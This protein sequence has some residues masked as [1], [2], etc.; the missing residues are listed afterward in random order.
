MNGSAAYGIAPQVLASVA[1]ITTHPR[2]Y[3]HPSSR[4]DVFDFWFGMHHDRPGLCPRPRAYLAKS[5]LDFRAVRLADGPISGR[6]R[7]AQGVSV[8]T[9][10]KLGRNRG[11]SNVAEQIDEFLRRLRSKFESSPG[12]QFLVYFQ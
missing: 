10:K 3:A 11:N 4:K 2:I 5:A 12:H 9:A 1:R 6:F 7:A 8:Q